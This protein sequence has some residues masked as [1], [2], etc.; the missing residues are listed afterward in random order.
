MSIREILLIGHT[1]HD[2]GYTNSPRLIDT[3]HGRI[4]DRVLELAD[5]NR[6]DGPDGFRWTFEVS[7]R[8]VVPEARPPRPCPAPG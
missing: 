4:V 7:A 6:A 3:M 8:A 2:V 1:H 5:E